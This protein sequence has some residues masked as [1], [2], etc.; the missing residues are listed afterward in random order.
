MYHVLIVDDAAV[1]RRGIRGLL[2]GWASTLS[3]YLAANGE[4]ALQII[5]SGVRPDILI[6]DIRMPHMNGLTLIEEIQY[7]GYEPYVIIV[8]A[9]D[10]FDYA[11]RALRLGVSDYLL[12]PVEPRELYRLIERFIDR[13]NAQRRAEDEA[14]ISAMEAPEA[15]RRDQIYLYRKICRI[16]EEHYSEDL[17]IEQIARRVAHSASH[18]SRVFADES[19]ETIVKYLTRVRMEKAADLLR[20]TSVRVSEISAMVGYATPTYFGQ[21][22]RKTYGMTPNAYR[23]KYG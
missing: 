18:I 6:T 13:L 1:E 19:G 21:V 17:S 9:H 12:K 7:R 14:S 23:E 2:S 5:E 8:S 11:R 4:E 20:N 10:E 16:L 15:E 22:F 3:C